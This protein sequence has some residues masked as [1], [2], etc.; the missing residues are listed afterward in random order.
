VPKIKVIPYVSNYRY[1]KFGEFWT[2]ERPP[3]WISK[4]ERLKILEIGIEMGPACQSHE[5]LKPLAPGYWSRARDTASRSWR[6]HVSCALSSRCSSLRSPHDSP[7]SRTH[8]RSCRR[9][10]HLAFLCRHTAASCA[11]T[12]ANAGRATPRRLPR[13]PPELGPPPQT[14]GRRSET[15]IS[16]SA[17][18]APWL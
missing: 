7:L 18:F 5:P 1:A 9:A 8:A 10:P 3:F 2:L 14:V 11:S 16:N 13:A 6:P 4:F 12:P 15:T 17:S